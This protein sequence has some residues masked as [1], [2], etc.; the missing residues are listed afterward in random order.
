MAMKNNPL[1]DIVK[2]DIDVSSPGSS[3]AS[4]DAILLVVPGPGES[5]EKTM[6]RTTAVSAADELLD[7]GFKDRKS[8]V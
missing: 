3:G 8:V 7:Y 2:C 1:N 6:E 4:F 5:G